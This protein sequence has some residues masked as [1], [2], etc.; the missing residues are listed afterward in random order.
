MLH[1]IQDPFG[2]VLVKQKSV[3]TIGQGEI[4]NASLASHFKYII[5]EG[6]GSSFRISLRTHSNAFSFVSL[7]PI[8]AKARSKRKEK[9]Q[10]SLLQSDDSRAFLIWCYLS[11]STAPLSFSPTELSLFFSMPLS[12]TIRQVSGSS[13]NT[14]STSCAMLS[15]TDLPLHG[16]FVIKF[17]ND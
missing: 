7:I 14:S 12:S 3:V 8:L 15:R 1:R 17:C 6:L 16:E 13:P 10:I 2:K 5:N 11:I 4:L 9:S